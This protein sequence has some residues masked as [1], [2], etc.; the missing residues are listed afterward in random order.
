MTLQPLLDAPVAVQAHVAGL[1]VAMAAGTWLLYFSRK[2][3]VGHRVLG[4]A[5]LGAMLAAMAAA[6]FIHGSGRGMPRFHGFS[7]THV[8]ALCVLAMVWLAVDAIRRRNLKRHIFAVKGLFFGGL[9]VNTLINVFLVH[10]VIHHAVFKGPEPLQ[11]RLE[12]PAALRAS[13]IPHVSI[14]LGAN[15]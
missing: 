15:R 3:S 9:I 2:G 11:A 4:F 10:G 5:F 7:P 1:L 6:F 13:P 14:D 8:L 12:A